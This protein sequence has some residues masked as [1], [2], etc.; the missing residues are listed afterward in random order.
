MAN[1]TTA[2]LL[3][4]QKNKTMVIIGILVIA[5]AIYF[6]FKGKK[7]GKITIADAPYINGK[8]AIPKGFN[9][10]ILADKLY[11]VMDGFFTASGT[12]DA[13]WL[14]LYQLA[15]DDMVVAVYNA[16]NEKYGIKR[17]GSLTQWIRDEKYFDP[18]SGVKTKAL[19]RL[20]QLRLT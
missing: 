5:I 11:D 1:S 20:S 17:N 15:T 18:L 9:P 16:F 6:Y 3:A 14:E 19:N 2:L 10:N 12:K 7:D 4:Y 13:A 8:D